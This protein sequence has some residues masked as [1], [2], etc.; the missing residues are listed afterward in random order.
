MPD[1]H[2]EMEKRKP[3]ILHQKTKL[4]PKTNFGLASAATANNTRE[5]KQA[6][7]M[8]GADK[9]NDNVIRELKER[10]P[11]S[12]IALGLSQKVSPKSY[13]LAFFEII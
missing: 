10:A 4:P 7:M 9:A 5:D 12:A 8:I 3:N 1:Y 13:R 11:L 2:R 6:I